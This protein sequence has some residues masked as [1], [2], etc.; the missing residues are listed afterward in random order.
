M[1]EITHEVSTRVSFI[2]NPIVV[3]VVDELESLSKCLLLN[4]D[5]LMMMMMIQR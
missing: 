2:R 3:T 4:R 1:L 5:E